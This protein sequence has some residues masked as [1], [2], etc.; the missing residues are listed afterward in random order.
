MIVVTEV[1]ADDP[2]VVPVIETHVRLMDATTGDPTACHRLDLSGLLA[3]HITFFAAFD[4]AAT[5]GIGAYAHFAGDTPPW[6]EV[7]SMHVPAEHRGRGI[8]RL[9]LDTI[10]A[11]AR[12]HRATVLRLETGADFE[13][14]IGLYTRAGFAPC[15]PFGDYPEHPFSRFFEKH[16]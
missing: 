9:V 12:A 13:A 11:T 8:S 1:R 3:P 7:K 14:A 16:L 4:G 5:V 10:E 15:G 6:G 2:R